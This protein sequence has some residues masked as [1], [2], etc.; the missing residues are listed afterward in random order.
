MQIDY[1]I[2]VVV[3]AVLF[4]Y[5]RLIGLQR[6]RAKRLAQPVPGG[7]QAK[8][9][10]KQRQEQ[11]QKRYS[12]V[13]ENPRDRVIGWIGAALVGLGVVMSS[14][15]L[16][17]PEIQSWWWLPTATGIVMFSWLFKI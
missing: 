3:G 17:F 13:S 1:R 9:R 15:L 12:L 11:I 8:A 16:P 10:G 7:K 6:E 5:L 2:V 14:G 4:F